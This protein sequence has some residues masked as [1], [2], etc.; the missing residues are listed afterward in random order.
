MR[1]YTGQV[2]NGSRYTATTKAALDPPCT[3]LVWTTPSEQNAR[4]FYLLWMFESLS[5]S[6]LH[7]QGVS[8]IPYASILIKCHRQIPL[9]QH[10]SCLQLPVRPS[11]CAR[12]IV[13]KLLNEPSLY[14]FIA[15][16]SQSQK[17]PFVL[18]TLSYHAGKVTGTIPLKHASWRNME[19]E[20]YCLGF[21]RILCFHLK[22]KL[23]MLVYLSAI[24][25]FAELFKATQMSC[26]AA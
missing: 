10:D 16:H 24:R 8:P 5:A 12:Y 20:R 14:S 3:H 6:Q 11:Q 7:I 22:T 2:Y 1:I 9:S 19:W 4:S 17:F 13:P 18:T 21:L 25:R 15:L 23:V 26:W